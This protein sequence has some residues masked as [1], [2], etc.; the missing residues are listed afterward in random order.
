MFTVRQSLKPSASYTR[1]R[2][3]AMSSYFQRVVT[4]W[5]SEPKNGN[6]YGSRRIVTIEN[7]KGKEITES[8]DK[9]GD[10]LVRKVKMTRR[11]GPALHRSRKKGKRNGRG[12][13]RKHA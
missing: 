9:H 10:V 3:S 2:S 1:I 12:K 11:I 4:E 13:T 7:G 5:A 8:L 6:V